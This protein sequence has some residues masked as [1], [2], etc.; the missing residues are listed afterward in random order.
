MSCEIITHQDVFALGDP[1]ERTKLRLQSHRIAAVPAML[2]AAATPSHQHDRLWSFTFSV[3]AK[4]G[5]SQR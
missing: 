4:V 3:E 2:S 1:A 5:W